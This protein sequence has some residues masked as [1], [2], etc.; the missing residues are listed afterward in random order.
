MVA[1]KSIVLRVGG[2]GDLNLREAWRIIFNCDF[3]A[4]TCQFLSTYFL[5]NESLVRFPLGACWLLD[6]SI[7]F[8][9]FG[10]LRWYVSLL[11]LSFLLLDK[12]E[13]C[14]GHWRS[15]AISNDVYVKT[16]VLLSQSMLKIT[17]DLSWRVLKKIFWC[18]ILLVAVIKMHMEIM[19]L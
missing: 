15:F 7:Q 12:Y 18:Q 14:C 4:L 5:G 1:N 11:P 13:C 6:N 2:C 9:K 17:G 3:W 16:F 10:N 8:L 19:F